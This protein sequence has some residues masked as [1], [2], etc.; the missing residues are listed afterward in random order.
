MILHA[1]G[2]KKRARGSMQLADR[3]FDM[4]NLE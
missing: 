4:P 1:V 2:R 3:L